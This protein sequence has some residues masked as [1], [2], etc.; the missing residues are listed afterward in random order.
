[1]VEMLVTTHAVH[2]DRRAE[3]MQRVA[4]MLSAMHLPH[5]M[6]EASRAFLS[7]SGATSV[8][9]HF[10]GALP[11][12]SGAVIQYLQRSYKEKA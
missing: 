10:R 7:M 2:C 1:M 9:R 12:S 8:P 3:E 4:G 6:S 5:A 11:S